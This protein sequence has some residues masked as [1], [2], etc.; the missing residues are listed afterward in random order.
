MINSHTDKLRQHLQDTLS[1]SHLEVQDD[2]QR[3]VS[4]PEATT[5][6]SRHF[7]IF[8]VSEQFAGKDLVERHRM[9]YEAMHDLFKTEV[10]AL[11]MKTL[12]PGEW[13]RIQPTLPTEQAD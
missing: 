1:P 5:P 3:Y 6:G 8:I 9:V 13:E 12:T 7:T 2:S 10:H 4:R 11:S